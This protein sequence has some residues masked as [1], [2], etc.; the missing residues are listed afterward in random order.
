[1]TASTFGPLKVVALGWGLSAV[2]VV[3]FVLCLAA[4]L[5]FPTWPAAHAWIGMYSVAPLTS[6]RVW[7][8]GIGFSIGFGWVAA[9]VLGL[10]Y[11]RLIAQ[12]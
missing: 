5:I 4:A 8:D 6:G 7:L 10:V 1:M 11:N 3:L 2:L 9:L 12:K